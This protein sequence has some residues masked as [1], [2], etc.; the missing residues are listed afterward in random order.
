LVELK[1]AN[2]DKARADLKHAVRLNPDLPTPHHALG[3]VADE[4]GRPKEAEAHY[5]DALKVDPGFA[6][7]R[8]NLGRL[9]FARGAFDDAR[10]QFLRLTQVAPDSREGWCGLVETVWRLGRYEEGNL[11][12]EAA[13]KKVGDVPA[14]LV[15]R[16]RQALRDG[17]A[18]D[19][20]AWLERVT[21]DASSSQAGDAWAWLAVARLAQG[22][23]G[24]AGQAAREAARLDPANAVAAFVMKRVLGSTP[25]DT[26]R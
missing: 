2:F 13:R 7:A 9:L 23:G 1:R 25:D 20:D 21:H 5:R 15:L 11:D 3:L 12:L 26:V 10:E 22:D 8:V 14:V 19:A 4:Q 18:A 24:G 6:P 16:A 17:D